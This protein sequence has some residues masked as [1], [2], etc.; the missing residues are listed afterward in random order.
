MKRIAFLLLAASSIGTAYAENS[1]SNPRLSY[2]DSC[3]KLQ[4]THLEVG[5]CPS[6]PKSLPEPED[7]ELGIS[8]FRT[9]VGDGDD[10]SNLSLPRTF[11]GRSQ[12]V[13]VSFQNSD[14]SESNLR[15]NDFTN[16]NFSGAVL[17][18]SDLRASALSEALFVGADLRRA[19]MRRSSFEDCDFTNA[20]LT[21]A[22]LTKTQGES[23]H[24]SSEQRTQVNWEISDGPEPSGG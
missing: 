22:V 1:M 18:G 13:D 20:D 4:G 16:V 14:L 15:W 6:I 5:E 3:R 12:I 24:L 7:E 19:D 2:E 21:E 11:M 10:L 9:F 17:A 8:F 23:L